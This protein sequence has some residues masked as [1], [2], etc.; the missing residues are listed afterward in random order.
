MRIN[1]AGLAELAKSGEL[2]FYPPYFL[3]CGI[4][5]HITLLLVLSY[6]SKLKAVSHE[7]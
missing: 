6:H 7:F 5:G 2:V 4:Y 1:Q 3:Y